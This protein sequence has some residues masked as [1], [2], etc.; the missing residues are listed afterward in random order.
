M[1]PQVIARREVAIDRVVGIRDAMC[2]AAI[3]LYKDCVLWRQDHPEVPL[4]S[5]WLR[6]GVDRFDVILSVIINLS[7][8][9]LLLSIPG[10][11]MRVFQDDGTINPILL[12]A[13]DGMIHA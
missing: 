2:D 12:P 3:Q 8:S 1:K 9:D 13:G 7:E 5:I 10:E 6:K 11:W 4:T